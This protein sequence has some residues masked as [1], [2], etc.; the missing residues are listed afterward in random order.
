ME[1]AIKAIKGSQLKANVCSRINVEVLAFRHKN[2]VK[3]DER[4][5]IV[6]PIDMKELNSEGDHY[7]EP[8]SEIA[9]KLLGAEIQDKIDIV[10]GKDRKM[11]QIVS[12][13]PLVSSY[14][15][16]GL[17]CLVCIWYALRRLN[18]KLD[19]MNGTT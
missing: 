11:L 16:V 4:S 13:D 19:L 6:A 5:Y 17:D 18:L 9:L 12:I 1:N 2:C 14:P 3:E 7:L 8:N 10:S 15:V